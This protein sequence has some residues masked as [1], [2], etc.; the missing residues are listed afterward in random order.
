MFP[1]FFASACCQS[2]QVAI[3]LPDDLVMLCEFLKQL[4][5]FILEILIA[6]INC[7][8]SLIKLINNSYV[9]FKRNTCLISVFI[10]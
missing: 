5:L 8:Q 6:K 7:F 10:Y 3:S 4:S 2:I 9:K 1:H